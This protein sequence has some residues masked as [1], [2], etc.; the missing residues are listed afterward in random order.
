MPPTST[1][2]LAFRFTRALQPDAPR[3]V[4]TCARAVNE[5]MDDARLAGLDPEADPAVLLLAR[6]MGRVAAGGDPEARHGEDAGLRAACTARIEQLR[7]ADVLVPL[8]R[9]GIG[10]DPH[11]IRIYKDAARSRL[12]ILAHELG[13][14]GDAYELRGLAV[15]TA[16]PPR[17]ELATARFRLQIDPDR[18][19]PGR[20]I[21]Y[22]RAEQLRGGW[23]GSPT[24]TEIGVLADISRFARTLRRELHLPASEQVASS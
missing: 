24:R 11:L 8:V 20:E 16:A 12:R 6:H 15:G 4:A 1:Y 23:T 18:M 17:F 3:I 7:S 9:R 2:D 22:M 10:F 21:T 13:F 19:I 14:S 5:A